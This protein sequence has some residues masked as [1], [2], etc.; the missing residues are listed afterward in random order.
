MAPSTATYRAKKTKSTLD[1]FVSS[2]GL[3]PWIRDPRTLASY[4]LSP[5]RP[6]LM[7]IAAQ[8]DHAIPALH[9]P[10]MLPAHIPMGPQLPEVSRHQTAAI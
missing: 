6:V 3:T 4:P 1:C 10:Q 9:R 5:H 2:H 8:D 7:D